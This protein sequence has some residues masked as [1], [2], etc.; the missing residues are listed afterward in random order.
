MNEGYREVIVIN[1]KTNNNKELITT[2]QNLNKAFY[3][4]LINCDD[5]EIFNSKYPF[6][7]CFKELACNVDD[8]VYSEIQ[9]RKE[10]I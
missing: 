4:V 7:K 10:S 5:E 2:L 1:K 3:E 8:W 9:N 6:N